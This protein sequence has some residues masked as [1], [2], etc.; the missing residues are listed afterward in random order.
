MHRRRAVNLLSRTDRSAS[1]RQCVGKFYTSRAGRP[2]PRGYLVLNQR[3]Q[4]SSPCTPITFSMAYMS[5]PELRAILGSTRV[6]RGSISTL[7][8]RCGDC[9]GT[10]GLAPRFRH[11]AAPGSA[12]AIVSHST[13]PRRRTTQ[14]HRQSTLSHRPLFHHDRGHYL[15]RT[16]GYHSVNPLAAREIRACG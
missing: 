3:S 14:A 11:S 9:R 6:A 13:V 5:L 15:I 2:E 4:G 12:G 8:R 1:R 10:S 7:A 16:R